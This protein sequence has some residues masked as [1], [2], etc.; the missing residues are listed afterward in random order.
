MS[1]LTPLNWLP[2][3]CL[4]AEKIVDDVQ[5][6]CDWNLSLKGHKQRRGIIML[7]NKSNLASNVTLFYCLYSVNN[8]PAILL[9]QG[10]SLSS[11]TRPY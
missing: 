5:K 2:E 11:K 3:W 7:G 1:C 6:G 4:D 10:D 8:H 9:V